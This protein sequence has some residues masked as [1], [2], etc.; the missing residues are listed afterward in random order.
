MTSVIKRPRIPLKGSVVALFFI[1]IVRDKFGGFKNSCYLCSKQI[2]R[3]DFRHIDLSITNFIHSNTHNH[4]HKTRH[5]KHTTRTRHTASTD[6]ASTDTEQD[7]TLQP[8]QDTGANAC[9]PGC[10][11]LK[12]FRCFTEWEWYSDTNTVRLFLHLLLRVNYRERRWKGIIIP[13]GSMVTSLAALA[14]ETTLSVQN[15]RTCLAHLKSTGEI[16]VET[17]PCYT[18]ITVNNYA[19][20]QDGG[21]CSNTSEQQPVNNPSTHSQQTCNKPLTTTKEIKKE[22]NKENIRENSGFAKAQPALAP[23]AE[24]SFC[25]VPCSECKSFATD[26]CVL[27]RNA[28]TPGT[29]T[30]EKR[31]AGA[32]ASKPA[33]STPAAVCTPM[34]SKP[35]AS[36]PTAVSTPTASKPAARISAVSTSDGRRSAFVAPDVE[37]V[38]QYAV[39]KGLEGFD[40]EAFTDYYSSNGWHVGKSPMRD[41]QAAVR[42]WAR[43]QDLMDACTLRRSDTARAAGTTCATRATLNVNDQWKGFVLPQR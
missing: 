35:A 11:W 33:A 8:L 13:R 31:G 26:G 21:T 7:R 27:R 6:R 36:T 2:C 1:K 43:R 23:Q 17:T 29:N 12:L 40:A 3:S 37:Q 5:A 34:A 4:E 38:R 32:A 28:A 30:V 10:G 9:V 15:V 42:N 41:W 14:A 25:E 20:Y 19:R 22:I 16:R 18:L 39:V 24:Q